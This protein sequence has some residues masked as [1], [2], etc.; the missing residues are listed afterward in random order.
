MAKTENE[1]ESALL[2]FALLALT[3]VVG[4]LM[5][6]FRKLRETSQEQAAELEKWHAQWREQR[7]AGPEDDVLEGEVL[8]E[9]KPRPTR[10]RAA[11]RVQTSP[12]TA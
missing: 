7:A 4:D 10:K 3:F 5:K 6:E 2:A 12:D 11:A 9:A 1:V 8:E